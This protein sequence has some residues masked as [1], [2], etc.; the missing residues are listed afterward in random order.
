MQTR[1]ARQTVLKEIGESGQRMIAGATAVVLGIGALGSN[2]ANLLARA[3]VG[4]LRLVDRDFVDWTNLQ[5]QSL[6][7][8]QDVI[9]SVPK[10]QA[11]V[12]HLRRINSTISCEPV[13]DDINA[14]TIERMIAG[15]AVVVDGLD[16]FHT[17]ALVNQACVKHGI[18]WIYGACLGTY[19]NAATIVPGTTAC[20]HCLLPGIDEA[21]TPPLTCETAGVLGPVPA[22]VAAWQSAEALKIIVGQRD[23]V[24]RDLMHFDLW[25]NDIASIPAQR[26][27]DCRVCTR[28]E[29]ELLEQGDRLATASLCGRDAVQIVPPASFELDFDLLCQTLGR[30]FTLERNSYLLK[31]RADKHEIVVFRDGRAMIF[32]TS[33]PKLALS[34][35]GKYIGG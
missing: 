30:L 20:L 24:S 19:G 5:R 4:T 27:A 17:R 23:A 12:Q 32:G 7:E 33:D 28:R 3:G 16:N 25:Q 34:L 14:R 22:L 2:S 35:Y 18:P 8:E 26:V 31:F 10:A 1:Y 11:A 21:T 9:Q 15:A 6:F 29:F 13:T